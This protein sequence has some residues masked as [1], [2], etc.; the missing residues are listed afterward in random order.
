[1]TPKLKYSEKVKISEAT[2]L[3]RTPLIEW[4][5]PQ[6]WCDLGCGSGAFTTALAQLLAPDS[7]IHAVDLDPRSLGHV[8]DHYD[9]VEIRKTLGDIG[10]PS[11]R[12]PS[13]DGILMA[14]T[15]HF[16]QDQQALMRRLL[17]VSDRF[18]IVEYERSK[19]NRWG[20]YP[21][22]FER[23]RELLT[24]AG[25]ERVKKLAIRPSLFGGTMYS[26]LAEQSR[27]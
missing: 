5:R 15:L 9:G 14:N 17:S 22:G 18:L 12:L 24:E 1:V 26:A 2:A 3:I 7:M 8:P 6:S 25:M 13:V 21:I 4:A 20:P 23:L 19:P 16:I 27:A 10:S 11:L